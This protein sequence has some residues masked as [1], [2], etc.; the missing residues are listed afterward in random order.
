MVAAALITVVTIIASLLLVAPNAFAYDNEEL[1]FQTLINNY[2]AQ[3]G[4][5]ALSL[6]NSL[7][8]AA[9]NHSYDMGIRGYFSHNT[10]EGVTPWDRIRSAGYT[11]NTWLGENIAAGYGSAQAVFDAWRVSPGHNAQMLGPNYR[12]IGIGR[13]YVNG[14]VYGWY[15]TTDFGGV[16][17]NSRAIDSVFVQKYSALGGAPGVATSDLQVITGGSYQ[18]FSNG[19]LYWNDATGGAY[20]IHGAILTKYDLLGSSILGLPTSDEYGVP[21]G[22]AHNFTGGRMTWSSATGAHEIHGVILSKFDSMGGTNVCGFPVSDVYDTPGFSGV[23]EADFQNARIYSSSAGTFEVHGAILSKYILSGGPQAFGLPT[24]NETVVSGNSSA[25]MNTFTGANIYW[26]PWTAAHIIYGEFLTY[27]TMTAGGPTG[28]LG[29]PA[30][31]PADINAL[32]ATGAQ[33]EIFQFGRIYT[34]SDHVFH[35]VHGAILSKYLAA[36]GPQAFGL[37]TSDEFIVPNFPSGRMNTFTAAHIYWSPGTGAHEVHGL[38]LVK[39][40]ELVNGAGYNTFGL[41]VTD[42]TSVPGYYGRKTEFQGTTIYWSGNTGAHEVR[43][44]IRGK[45]LAA[46]GPA[47]FGLPTS[48]ETDAPGVVDG[49]YSTFQAAHVYWSPT[50]NAHEVH[51]AILAKYLSEGASQSSLGLPT[52]DEYYAGGSMYVNNF[53]HGYIRW[54]PW[55]GALVQVSP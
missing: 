53:Q 7:Y 16:V 54:T 51:G 8:N 31:D 40:I 9:E 35:E 2:R 55:T 21:G 13:Y 39:Y 50:T 49:R 38:I 18:N 1:A 3:N 32:G 46:G 6:S 44:A 52:S 5:P 28:F 37:P 48:D 10:P 14:S 22:R 15:W 20:W 27:Y 47:R 17:D 12:A 34:S 42:E 26:S 43:G 30:S 19:R 24:S 25:R 29:L 11:Y 4:L 23:Q 45:W 41:P 33:H 36:G